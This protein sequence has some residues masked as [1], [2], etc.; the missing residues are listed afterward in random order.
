MSVLRRL[1][2]RYRLPLIHGGLEAIALT[3]SGGWPRNDELRPGPLVVSGF[4][5]ES[6]GVGRAGRMSADALEAAGHAVIRHDL[7]PAF[8]HI[9]DGKA[10]LPGASAGGVW[11]IH[12]NAP[13]A[14]VAL[15]THP[16]DQWR[17]RYRIGYWAWETPQAPAQW[18]RVAR[19]L[20]E[21]WTPSAYVR[22]A[23][24]RAFEA[25]GQTHLPHVRVMPHPLLGAAPAP[26]RTRFG[27]SANGCEVLSLFDVQSSPARKNPWASLEAW[28]AA[29]PA[30]SPA[31]TLTLKVSALDVA[32]EA[33]LK[34]RIGIRSDIRL[35]TERLSDADMDRFIA[36]FDILLSLHRSEG[37]GLGLL[38][39]MQAGVCVVATD[40]SGND[41]LDESNG[42][43]V[44][45]RL[46]PLND[47]DGPY[48]A[49]PAA[50]AQVWAE[51]DLDAAATLLRELSGDRTLR[52]AKRDAARTTPAR[53]NTA[54]SPQALNAFDF[55]RWLDS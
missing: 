37:F 48:S 49:V 35:Y 15:M 38:E 47:P 55:N 28:L 7:R 19:W 44:P 45:Y 26:D 43:P 18:A 46:I 8:R 14:L 10:V 51:P 50:P 25:S 33:R 40:G 29:F 21:I 9:P 11:L 39:A 5:N 54:W 2:L 1:P 42:Y 52:S 3:R 24:L 22:D 53:L 16:P 41:F 6:L 30:P 12:A 36:S 27:L 17:H 34:A 31:A 32:T 20:H 13:E 4:F 23:L